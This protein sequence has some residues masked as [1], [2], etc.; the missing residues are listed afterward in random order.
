MSSRAEAIQNARRILDQ[1]P[2]YL[3][4]ETTGLSDQDEI[5]EIGII[6][7][8]GNIFSEE[9]VKPYRSIPQ[10]AT[11]LHGITNDMVRNARPWPMVWQTLRSLINTK[12]IAI[13][14]D[15]FDLRMMAQS[16]RQYNLVW[17]ERLQ[18]FDV[19]RCFAQYNGE[20]NPIK[21]AF[22]FF[23]LSEAGTKFQISIPNA[24]RAV[25]D[26]LLT[27]AVLMAIAAQDI[28]PQ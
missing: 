25:Q 22:R 24:H 9:F 14:N 16:Y 10:S 26:C 5:V 13:Y 18:T 6:D 4:T 20:W 12:I 11:Y 7:S 8:A 21:H 1:N 19:M 15:G 28:D 2:I 27:R 17:K 3:D 23:K